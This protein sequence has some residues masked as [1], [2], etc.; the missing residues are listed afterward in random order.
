VG[1]EGEVKVFSCPPDIKVVIEGYVEAKCPFTGA[2][3]HYELSVEYVSRGR[4][5]EA[6]SFSRWLGGFKGRSISQE[7]LAFEILRFVKSLVDPS[8]VCVRLAGRHGSLD[9]S[10]E[11]CEEGASLGPQAL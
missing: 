4:C 6:I 3:D 5:I 7:E 1:E 8:M 10:V 2:P 9:L 11:Y